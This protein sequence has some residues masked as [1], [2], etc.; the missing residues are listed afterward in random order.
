MANILNSPLFGVLITLFSFFIGKKIYAKFKLSILNPVLTAMIFCIAFLIVTKIDYSSYKLGGDYI[1]FF[2]GPVTVVLAVP[3]YKQIDKLKEHFII[4]N[5]GILTGVVS[6]LISV[7]LFGK[8]FGFD[9]ELIISMI[10]KSITT[11]V[12]L[13]LS[14]QI[15]GIPSITFVSI[16]I[17]GFTGPLISQMVIK[18]FNIKDPIAKGVAMG[19]SSHAIG[20]IKAI[21]YG[22][23][24]GAMSSL[25]IGIAALMTVLLSP[26]FIGIFF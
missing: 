25:S 8:I 17:T 23:A 16:L 26:I 9:S 10:P 12:G 11:P 5:T 22:E 13:E 21:E 4:I 18:I 7:I 15:G 3:L 2:L 20:T 24:E 6:S 14:H 19:T 1:Q